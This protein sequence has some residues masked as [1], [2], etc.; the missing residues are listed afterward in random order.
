M[1]GTRPV[2]LPPRSPNLNLHIER[3]MPRMK[4]ECLERMIFFGKAPL[5][6]TPVEFAAHYHGERNHQNWATGS[7]SRALRSNASRGRSPAGTG[8]RPVAL[9]TLQRRIATH[10][11][12]LFHFTQFQH[13]GIGVSMCRSALSLPKSESGIDVTAHNIETSPRPLK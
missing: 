12:Y 11:I 7:L 4:S 3:F 13:A 1:H 5:R 10:C 6:R 8:S 2:L 9:L